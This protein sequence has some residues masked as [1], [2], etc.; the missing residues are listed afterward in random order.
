MQ[1]SR[2]ALTYDRH[3]LPSSFSD[4]MMEALWCAELLLDS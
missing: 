2:S 4:L 1:S 3:V